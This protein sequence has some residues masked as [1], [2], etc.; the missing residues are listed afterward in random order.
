MEIGPGLGSALGGI[1]GAATDYRIAQ[2]NQD[3]QREFAQQGVRWRVEDAKAA[4]VHPLYALGSGVTPFSPQSTSFS[5]AGQNIGRAAF[6]GKTEAERATEQANL[7]V[8]RSQTARNDAEAAWFASRIRTNAEAGNVATA[9]PISASQNPEIS[10]LYRDALT[11]K[12]DE[13]VS[14]HI[15]EP[16]QTAGIDHPGVREFLLPGGMRALLPNTGAQGG[17][18]EDIDMSL[19]PFIL[20]ANI[21]KYGPRWLVDLIGYAT[22]RSPDDRR[23]SGT[24]ESWL[25]GGGL[26]RFIEGVDRR[27]KSPWERR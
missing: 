6:S 2:Q 25:K 9:F 16:G 14:R 1:V 20:G 12:P 11:L 17:M 13:M 22:G 18:P 26:R 24:V 27:Y 23:K 5:E 8:M 3:M 19:I 7:E 10:A 4:G 15:S 21:E